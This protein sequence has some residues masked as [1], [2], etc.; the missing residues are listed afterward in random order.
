MIDCLKFHARARAR[1]RARATI[2]IV[3]LYYIN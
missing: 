1:A 3:F 2:H